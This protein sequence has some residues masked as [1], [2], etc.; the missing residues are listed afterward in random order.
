MGAQIMIKVTI[1][2][3][4]LQ[5]PDFAPEPFKVRPLPPPP[6]PQQC[7]GAGKAL[8]PGP[9][10]R[11]SHAFSVAAGWLEMSQLLTQTAAAMHGW[12]LPAVPRGCAGLPSAASPPAPPRTHS[13][14]VPPRDRRW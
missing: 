9:P 7:P 4:Q 12:A 5:L 6:W 14:A 11:A 2:C 1:M 3:Q 13:L 8:P 10:S